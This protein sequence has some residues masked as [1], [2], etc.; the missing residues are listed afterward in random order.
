[1]EQEGDAGMTSRSGVR[2]ALVS[3]DGFAAL[4]AGGGGIALI[5]G[6]EGDQFPAE[7]L[8]GTPFQSNVV[9]GPILGAVV[10]EAPSLP[11][12]LLCAAR[13]SVGGP[14]RSPVR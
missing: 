13:D 8:R 12:L 7:L 9:P 10:A 4:T 6:L 1:M 2:S 3:L 14:Q 11:P 5:T